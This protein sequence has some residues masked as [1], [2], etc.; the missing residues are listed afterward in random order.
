MD[1]SNSEGADVSRSGTL[2]RSGSLIACLRVGCG[3][4]S[5]RVM[6]LLLATW[7]G[8]AIYYRPHEFVRIQS[9]RAAPARH[10]ET[11]V[12]SYETK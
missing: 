9:F 2:D 12:V 1:D 5:R 10:S 6:S 4:V 11:K 7:Y 3:A 8:E